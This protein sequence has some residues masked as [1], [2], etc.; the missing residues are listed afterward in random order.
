MDAKHALSNAS[1]VSTLKDV[2]QGISTSLKLHG[3][4]GFWFQGIPHCAYEN[5][6]F[7]EDTS[8]FSPMA[9]R[10]PIASVASSPIVAQLQRFYLNQVAANDTN[11]GFSLD[12]SKPYV[13]RLINEKDTKAC[14]LFQKHNIQT[15]LSWPIV[16]HDQC[17]WTGRFMLLS[18][19]S[20]SEIVL[21]GLADVL[22]EAQY[23]L[24]ECNKPMFNPFLQSSLLKE[25]ARDI[26]QMVANG[27]QNDEIS[28]QIPISVRGV[29]YH[30]ESMRKKFGAA[31]RAN[32]IHLAHQYELI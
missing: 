2:I 32:L 19:Q 17:R 15:V 21:D 5:Y 6:H 27:L 24:F 1:T 23:K 22:K 29:E 7:P 26:L 25:N 18:Q 4:S 8:L 28:T 9:L 31:N 3:F 30:M 10:K 20:Y 14:A 12:T 16:C 11:F 13:Y